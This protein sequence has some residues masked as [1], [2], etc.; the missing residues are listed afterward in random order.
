MLL[1]RKEIFEFG[2]FRLDV[3]EHTIERIDGVQNGSLTEKAFQ[4]L[5]L[6]VRRRGHLVTKDELIQFIWPDTL[7]Q[8]KNLEKC[9]HHLRHFLVETPDRTGYIDTVRKHGYRFVGNV[10]AIEVS[11]SW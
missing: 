1:N 2:E 8:D 11:G 6:L 5:V 3:N 10:Q 9:I 4:A 7:V